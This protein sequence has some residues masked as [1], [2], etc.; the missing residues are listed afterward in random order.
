MKTKCSVE[1]KLK[2]V[3]VLNSDTEYNFHHDEVI[4]V[5]SAEESCSTDEA[6]FLQRPTRDKLT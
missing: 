6:M 3:N 1:T 4:S 2:K 5:E